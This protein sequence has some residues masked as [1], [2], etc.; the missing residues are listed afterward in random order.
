M[1]KNLLRVSKA[2]WIWAQFREID[3]KYLSLLQ[4][5]VWK[6]LNSPKFQPHLTLTGPYKEI[7]KEFKISL[8]NLCQEEKKFSVNLNSYD[9]KE[10]KYES[11]YISLKNSQELN[12][13]REK[14]IQL[15]KIKY[16]NR[17]FNPHISLAYGDFQKSKKIELKKRLSIL[18]EVLVIDKIAIV[19]VNENDNI[20]NITESINLNK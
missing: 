17:M 3:S 10:L 6:N 1:S 5:N 12:N 2:Y 11:F 4:K 20:W 16:L 15:K 18:K 13:L 7:N 19:N 8:I 14:I 9:F